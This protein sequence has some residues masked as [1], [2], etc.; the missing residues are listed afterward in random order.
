MKLLS[1]LPLLLMFL[2][3]LVACAADKKAAPVEG[4]DYTLIDGGQPYAP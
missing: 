3:P 4:E 1:R 2:L